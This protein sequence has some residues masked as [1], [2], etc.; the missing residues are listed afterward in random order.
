MMLGLSVHFHVMSIFRL[1]NAQCLCLML[2]LKPIL[3]LAPSSYSPFPAQLLQVPWPLGP[4]AFGLISSRS[5][6]HATW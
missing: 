4:F 6:E 5:T 3:V 1:N 2:L